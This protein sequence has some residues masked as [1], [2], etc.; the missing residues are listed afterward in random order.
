LCHAAVERA[1]VADEVFTAEMPLPTVPLSPPEQGNG[2]TES[3]LLVRVD[4]TY[5]RQDFSLMQEVKAKGVWPSS[6]RFDFVVRKRPM[7]DA[8]AKEL[9]KRLEAHGAGVLTPYQ[10]AEVTALREMTGRDL[11]ARAEAWR[12]F[13]KKS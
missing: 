1:K 10:K 9:R 13:L 3:P 5:L 6:Q 12:K 8:E 7:S 4:V 11:E 2:R